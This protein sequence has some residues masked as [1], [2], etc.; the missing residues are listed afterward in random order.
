[1]E[2]NFSSNSPLTFAEKCKAM[3]DKKWKKLNRLL[4]ALLGLLG[5]AV[6]C[7][8]PDTATFGD[9]TFMVVAIAMLILPRAVENQAQRDVGTGRMYM[10][11]FFALV[12]AAYFAVNHFGII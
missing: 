2:N 3:D 6:L 9:Y 8:T 11:L 1:M 5:G 12:L 4:G 7:F 10:I